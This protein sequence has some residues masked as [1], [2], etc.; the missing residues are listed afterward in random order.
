MPG[1]LCGE[2]SRR[3]TR[4]GPPAQLPSPPPSQDVKLVKVYRADGVRVEAVRGVDIDLGRRVRRHHWDR[5]PSGSPRCRARRSPSTATAGYLAAGRRLRALDGRHG[6][7]SAAAHRLSCFLIQHAVQ[8]A[9]G[10]QRGLPALP[11]ARPAQA[12]SRRGSSD[13]A[14]ISDKAERRPARLSGGERHRVALALRAGARAV[15]SCSPTSRPQL[16]TPTRANLAPAAAPG[17]PGGRRSDGTHDAPVRG[18]A[19]RV[20]TW[21]DGMVARRPQS[22]RS[23]APLTALSDDSGAEG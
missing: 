20:L 2:V 12:R 14:G 6:P 4:P 18:L 17:A 13:R 7:P 16:D 8:H 10:R 15:S 22:C 3:K 23:L 9:G 5:R 19:D 21:F 11:R 1:G